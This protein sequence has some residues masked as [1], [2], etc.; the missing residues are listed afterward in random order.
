MPFRSADPEIKRSNQEE[1]R[2]R[3]DTETDTSAPKRNRG[4]S[5][6]QLSRPDADDREARSKAEATNRRLLAEHEILECEAADLA[7][8][9][10]VVDAQFSDLQVRGSVGRLVGAYVDAREIDG[11]EAEI[12][13]EMHLGRDQIPLSMLE[14]RAITPVPSNVQASEA[15][16]VIPVFADGDIAFLQVPQVRVAVGDATYPVLTSRPTVGG[17]HR[18]STSVAET[19]GT[20]VSEVLQP[21]RF[22]C[23]FSFRRVDAASFGSMDSA[24]T[25]ALNAG[26]TEALDKSFVDQVITDSAQVSATAVDTFGTYR[27][28]LVLDRIDGRWSS[29]EG[30]IRVLVGAKTMVHMGSVYRG[31]TADDS[32]LDSVRR[33]SG[34]L[35]VSAHIAAV[36]SSKQDA[37]IR[38]GARQDAVV[39][40]W[41]SVSLIRDEITSAAKG[42]VKLTAVLLAAMK[43]TRATGFGQIETQ[44]A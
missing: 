20:L 39:A 35:K 43:V 5:P 30:D 33:I 11:V 2:K 14:T 25:A 34:G 28:K 36:A 6:R 23:G 38:R 21:S 37:I 15:P 44:H 32:A 42:E 8:T 19:T 7:R 26:L 16:T 3:H 41:P 12:L 17:G 1:T 10:I 27:S 22:Q 18:D 4:G 24:L 13:S 40:L 9:N 31:N 29:V